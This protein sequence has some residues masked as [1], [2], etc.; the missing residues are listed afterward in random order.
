MQ[1]SID[2]NVTEQSLGEL[3]GLPIPEE[4]TV[5]VLPPSSLTPARIDDFVFRMEQVKLLTAFFCSPTPPL[6]G[7]FVHGPF[8]S[9]KTSVVEQ[10][11]ARLGLSLISCDWNFESEVEDLIGTRDI[12]FGDTT[13]TPGPLVE[14]MRNGHVL[15]INEIDRGRPSN[16]TGLHGILDGAPLT[17]KATNEVIRAHPDFRL[18]VTANSA[19]S[20]DRG[21]QYTGSVRKQDPAFLDRFAFLECVYM[22]EAEEVDLLMRKFPAFEGQLVQKLV[23]FAGETRAKASDVAAELAIPLSTRTLLRFLWLAES[24]GISG[25]TYRD[26]SL[27][28][29]RPALEPTYLFRLDDVERAVAEK[30]LDS[31]MP[32]HVSLSP[33]L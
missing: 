29:L 3:F 10:F 28:T 14:A 6:G 13:F 26:Q 21:G 11:C 16:L 33:S 25:I 15:L 22:D 31:M 8:G 7:L 2:A 12:A 19:G 17:I 32:N 4:V 27:D 5:G 23:E 18:I 20:G 1:V 24:Y 9:G 30:I